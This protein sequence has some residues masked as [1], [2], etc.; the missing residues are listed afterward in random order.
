MALPT[1]RC[2]QAGKLLNR[3]KYGLQYLS[4]LLLKLNIKLGGH[5]QYPSPAGCRLSMEKP[6]IVL[7]ADP[8]LEPHAA[9][10]ATA[11]SP[12]CNRMQRSMALDR[13]QRC[14]AVCNA[15]CSHSNPSL[16]PHVRV[17]VHA[18]VCP[19]VAYSPRS[20]PGG[21]IRH[22]YDLHT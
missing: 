11:C 3:D 7:G 6:T 22:A 2:V 19:V 1:R 12:G 5:N 10:A 4:N 16:Q 14:V 15:G 13:L 17:H 9:Q 21:P 18:H 20:L 8:H